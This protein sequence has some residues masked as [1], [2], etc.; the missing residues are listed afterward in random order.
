MLVE[1]SRSADLET[2]M[3]E[4]FL[5]QRKALMSRHPQPHP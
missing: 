2:I 1:V 4:Q 5:E 3:Q